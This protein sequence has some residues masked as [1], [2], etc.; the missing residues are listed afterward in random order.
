[1]TPLRDIDYDPLKADTHY[2]T[3]II[4]NHGMIV[5]R[6]FWDKKQN[7]IKCLTAKQLLDVRLLFR[8]SM[9]LMQEDTCDNLCLIVT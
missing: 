5:V 1:M 6:G 7:D 4:V 8:D 9:V 2:I 3:P